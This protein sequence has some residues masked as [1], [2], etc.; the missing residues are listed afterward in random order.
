MSDNSQMAQLS[1]ALQLRKQIA[2]D[3]MLKRNVVAC[4]VGFKIAGQRQTNTPSIVVSVRHKEPASALAPADLVPKNVQD[5]LT[6]VVET[7]EIVA[8][9]IDRRT[10]V[11]PARPGMSVGHK[12]GSTGTI[13]CIVKQGDRRFILSNNH[14]LA[15]INQ[16]QIGDAIL[17]PGLADGGT[18]ANAIGQ[19]AFFVPLGFLDETAIGG[20]ATQATGKTRSGQSLSDVFKGVLS[21]IKSFS[22]PST[23]LPPA[24]SLPENKVDVALA[25]PLQANMIDSTIVDIGGPPLGKVDPRLGMRVVKSGRTSGVTEGVISQLDVTVNVTY[26]GRTA[27]F[28]NQIITSRLSQPGDSGSLVLDFER[29]A[30]GLLFSGS[31]LVSVI[32]PISAVLAAVGAELVTS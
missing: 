24:V 2:G 17:Q 19:L 25:A 15:A 11:R 28:T 18:L 31:D 1:R 30:V 22:T 20:A 12:D 7:G 16:G 26:G 23:A 21:G 5:V 6:D 13:G 3:F 4:G 14:V 29:R 8:H 27:R 32:S 9:S 10:A